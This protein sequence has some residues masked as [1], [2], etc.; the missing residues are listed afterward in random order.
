MSL[1]ITWLKHASFRLA[2]KKDETVIYIDPWKIAAQPHDA[3]VVFISH[4]HFDHCSPQDVKNISKPDGIV[5]GPADA[6]GQFSTG[7]AI[8]PG[9]SIILGP[10]TIEAV[11]AYNIGKTF[12]PKEKG[13]CGAI[14]SLAGQ[15]VYFAGDTDF[16]PEM[17]EL[18]DIDLALLPIGGTYTMT[19][20]EAARACGDIKPSRAIPC[21]W[22]E[23]I[24]Q[25]DDAKTFAGLAPCPVTIL[26]PG[27]TFSIAD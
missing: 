3:D 7:K 19:A 23:I 18:H 4:D 8:S 5:I 11:P 12:H 1:E 27:Q 21:H 6:A 2:S 22:G 20:T 24:G 9:Q 17:K 26:Q 15:R 10:I 14:I 13:W 16:I 25:K